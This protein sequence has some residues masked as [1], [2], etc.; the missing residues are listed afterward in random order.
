MFK[1]L[2]CLYVSIFFLKKLIQGAFLDMLESLCVH[3]EKCFYELIHVVNLFK[4]AE[5]GI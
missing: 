5:D 2:H 1:P 4:L 3:A